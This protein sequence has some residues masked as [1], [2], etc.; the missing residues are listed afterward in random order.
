MDDHSQLNQQY[1]GLHTGRW[2][3]Q[4]PSSWIPYIQLARLSPPLGLL[5]AYFPHLF[6]VLLGGIAT[7]APPIEMLRASFVLLF[8]SCFGS[9]VG[10]ALNDI[11]DKPFDRRVI[12]TRTRPIARGAITRNAALVFAALNLAAL[13]LVIFVF[14][15][16][17][18]E[19]YMLPNLA[20][21]LYYPFAKRHTHYSQL[22]LG[23]CMSWTIFIGALSIGH[24]PFSGGIFHL[25]KQNGIDDSN[26]PTM[27]P[28]KA[29][30]DIGV[31]SLFF[32]ISFWT[33]ISD[34]VYA[35]QDIKDDLRLDL[36]SMATLCQ[37]HTKQVLS[38]FLTAMAISLSICGSYY[39]LGV[40]YY[41]ISI[42]GSGA[43]LG[44]MLWRVDLN[45][46]SSC[47]WWFGIGFEA[48]Y[49]TLAGG[50]LL[51]YLLV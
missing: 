30:V 42:G 2:V 15:P 26:L 8:Y 40:L 41:V 13:L 46:P 44:I 18:T 11:V 22:V 29:E 9:N 25:S 27:T 20:A 3:D 51:E 4:L 32:A 10:H 24:E 31:L 17:G 1:G 33:V 5:M 34:T 37:G 38:I 14:L 7:Q 48:V 21:V 43:V 35:H 36:K 28:R 23:F 12:R 6:G 16:R 47:W 49:L 45:D 50:L 39:S 19:I